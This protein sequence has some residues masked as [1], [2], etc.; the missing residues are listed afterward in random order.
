MDDGWWL[1]PAVIFFPPPVLGKQWKGQFSTA[2]SREWESRLGETTAY[3]VGTEGGG[4]YLYTFRVCLHF[5]L[6]SS[7]RLQGRS[8]VPLGGEVKSLFISKSLPALVPKGPTIRATY[9]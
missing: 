9:E 7:R 4:V 8:A 6:G 5:G 2:G 1:F 3:W